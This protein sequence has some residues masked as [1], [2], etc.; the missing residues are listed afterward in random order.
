MRLWKNS[1]FMRREFRSRG[2]LLWR[3]C[4]ATESGRKAASRT[5]EQAADA[6]LLIKQ[7]Q[8][9]HPLVRLTD[10]GEE[11]ARV[12]GSLSDPVDDL[13]LV[14]K[15]D[16]LCQ[17]SPKAYVDPV[18]K[19]DWAHE[20]DLFGLTYGKP[21]A[22]EFQQQLWRAQMSLLSAVRRGWVDSLS[23]TTR[24]IFY[25]T[26]EKWREEKPTGFKRTFQIPKEFN[27]RHMDAYM[28]GYREQRDLMESTE[29]RD[30]QEI[31]RIPLSATMEQRKRRKGI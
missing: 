19:S 20:V 1:Y 22:E 24:N 4:E 27:E 28:E 8:R 3:S 14:K 15:L 16:R 25:R 5:L 10:L 6:G 23:N 26:T 17:K 30:H 29:T 21:N 18:S 13:K 12:L 31:G 9:N 2:G 7:Q 11:T